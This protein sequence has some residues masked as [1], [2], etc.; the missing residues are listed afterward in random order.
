MTDGESVSIAVIGIGCRLPGGVNSPESLWTVLDEGIDAWSDVPPDRFRWESFYEHNPATQGCMNHR[1]GHFLQQDVATFDADFFGIPPL[2]AKAIDPQQRLLLETTY[3]AIESAG[4]SL[5]KFKGSETSVF[6]ESNL[7]CPVSSFVKCIAATFANDYNTMLSKDM[8]DLTPY[9]LLGTGN[10]TFSN[11]I[12]YLFDLTGPSVTI[13]TGCSGSLVAIHQVCK[14]SSATFF[15]THILLSQLIER[16]VAF[17]S[18]LREFAKDLTGMSKLAK[19]RSQPCRCGWCGI[20]A[21]S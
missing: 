9:Q 18:R 13:D 14:V 19:S 11:R 2:E 16:M 10:A 20:D 8:D 21:L 12:S 7:A 4:I 3:E 15:H 17:D 1:G 6:G 5:D